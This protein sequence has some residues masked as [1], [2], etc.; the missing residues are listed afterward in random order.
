MTGSVVTVGSFD[1]MHLGHQA[2]VREA[3]RLG[4][5]LGL[6][7]TLV[8]FEPHPTAVLSP[9]RA[10]RRLSVGVERNEAVAELGLDRVVVLR[11]DQRLAAL[12]APQFVQEVLLS[13]LGMRELV[14]GADHGFGHGRAGD[15]RTLPMLGRD[16]GFGVTVVEPLADRQGETVSSSR[17]R[18]AVVSG[19][20]AV[21]ALGLGRP[22]R[23]TGTVLRGAG[24]GRT[25]GV[26]TLNLSGPAPDKALPPDGVYAARVEWGGGTAGAMLNQGPRPTVGDARRTIEAHLFDFEG[27][28][29][30]RTVRLEWVKQIR[31]VRRFPSLDALRAQLAQD[32]EQALAIL[33]GLPE[34]S[35]APPT[36]GR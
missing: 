3:K 19:E 20:L 17:I 2:V 26:P 15:R 9:G 34:T 29:Y 14:L 23:I 31:E 30:G 21:A 8:T 4:E 5:R 35:T 33:A 28:L 6:P 18:A 24:R 10:P 32:R 27:D 22:Y 16:L 11:F 12:D 1:G 36:G 13:R 7:A 25:I